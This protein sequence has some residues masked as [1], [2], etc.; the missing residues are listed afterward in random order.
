MRRSG[1]NFSV[2]AIP[3]RKAASRKKVAINKTFVF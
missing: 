1:K 3:R 2:S